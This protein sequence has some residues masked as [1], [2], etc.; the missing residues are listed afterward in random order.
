MQ[1]TQNAINNP[2]I[3]SKTR[4]HT[5]INDGVTRLIALFN[6]C[7]AS[8][9]QADPAQRTYLIAHAS[10]P[11]YLPF[12]TDP[13]DFFRTHAHHEK[14]SD[15]DSDPLTWLGAQ[16]ISSLP[17]GNKIFFNRDYFA[18]ALHEI[19][20]WC[21]AGE[22]RRA[23]VDYG[24][25]YAPDGRDTQQ[26]RAFEQVEVKPQ[27]LEWAFSLACNA[28]FSVS[29]DNLSLSE[30]DSTAFKNAVTKQLM[31]YEEHGFPKRAHRFLS[32]LQA[33]F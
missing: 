10:E 4:A 5:S 11:I 15:H 31:I 26:Q 6:G 3:F 30:H 13:A 20:H 27:A 2:S 7:F 1:Y 22:Q 25:W 29:N 9:D 8:E 14:Q 16:S 18:S 24:Y 28:S 19:A 33:Q 23:Q 17:Q 12:N 21:I 32:I